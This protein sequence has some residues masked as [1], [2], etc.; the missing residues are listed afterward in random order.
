MIQ[1]LSVCSL[2][3]SRSL[4]YIHTGRTR[5]NEY[6]QRPVFSAILLTALQPHPKTRQ[7]MS[8]SSAHLVS[9][10]RFQ[11]G[12]YVCTPGIPWGLQAPQSERTL[13]TSNRDRL[14]TRSYSIGPW[15]YKQ[16]FFSTIVRSLLFIEGYVNTSCLLIDYILFIQVFFS[17]HITD[18]PDKFFKSIG[19]KA[20]G[21]KS[22]YLFC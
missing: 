4:C 6:N 19:D 7:P 17:Y 2:I 18:Y 14:H 11:D 21:S 22:V 5:N 13:L 15:I 12:R 20:D 1:L 3:I 16:P 10:L 8:Q 9:T